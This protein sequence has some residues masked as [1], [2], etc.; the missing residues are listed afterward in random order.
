LFRCC[1]IRCGRKAASGLKPYTHFLGSASAARFI[2]DA[3]TSAACAVAAGCVAALR[4][5]LSAKAKPPAQLFDELRGTANQVKGT[6][7][8]AEYGFGIIDPAA[9]AQS[10]G[11]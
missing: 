11:L 5:R 4:T 6:G 1:G 10:L 2:P 8:N 3:G 7:W 9:A